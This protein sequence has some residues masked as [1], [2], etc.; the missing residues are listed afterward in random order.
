MSPPASSSGPRFSH[1]TGQA[2]KGGP[3][4]GV[5]LQI[6]A[7]DR[8]DCHS[9]APRELRR[10]QSRA[11]PGD[12]DILAERGRRALR[13]ILTAIWEFRPCRARS[14]GRTRL[15]VNLGVSGGKESRGTCRSASSVSG[16]SA[17]SITRRLLRNGHDAVV[18]DRDAKAV[19]AL[20]RDGATGTAGFD[21]WC[22]NCARRARSGEVAGR[23][24]HRGRH[25]GAGEIAAAGD[26]VIDG[27]N[28]F[29][30]DDIRRAKM[31]KARGIHHVDVGTSG[32][33]WG[34]ERGYCMMIGGRAKE[35]VDR[36]DPIFKALAPGLGNVPRTPGRDGHD[37]RAERG[38]IHAGANGAG[39]FV[40]MVHNGIEY[41]LMQAFAEGFD[42]LRN[43]NSGALPE[44]A[45]FDLDLAD[46]AEVW[47]R[48]SVVSSWLLDLDGERAG[49]RSETRRLRRRG[50]GFPAK[51]AGPSWPRSRKRCRP[52]CFR[53]ALRALPLA[54]PT[55]FCG[56]NPAPPCAKVSAITSSRETARPN[57]HDGEHHRR[58]ERH[59]GTAGRS[60]L[61]RNFR[62]VG[63]PH[64]PLAGARAL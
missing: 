6:T 52:M 22:S 14:G 54:P 7:N 38:Y 53:R 30:Q 45:R 49:R 44:D 28:T 4:S 33:V 48:G 12:F 46:I 60:V 32:G 19:A 50:R 59:L 27:G 61:P 13:C 55:Y 11:G 47:R 63:R 5:F 29:W 23:Q 2:Y 34:L 42:I 51:A 64:P 36:L 56:K 20:G 16:A 21:S 35:I 43:A 9:R 15:G 62:R 10:G 3:D 26:I 1:S 8:D 24:D 58:D 41:G 31:L 37:P 25:R 57:R 39:H 18:Y 17:A 40:K